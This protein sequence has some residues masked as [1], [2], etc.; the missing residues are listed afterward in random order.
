[1]S[2][3]NMKS[4][5]IAALLAVTFLC[6][7]AGLRARQPAPEEFRR[8]VDL[9]EH[10]LFERAGTLFGS[11]FSATGDVLAK[12]YET[13]CSVRLQEA[14]YEQAVS[15]YSQAYPYS[16]LIPQLH[17]YSGLNLFDKED[18]AL[19]AREFGKVS[20]RDLYSGQIAE[21]SFKKAYSLFEN[22]DIQAAEAGF[23][24]A[25]KMPRSDYTAPSRYSLGYIHYAGKNFREA[26]DW[27]E[28]AARDPRFADISRYY[29]MECRFMQKDYAYVVKNGTGIFESVPKERQMHLARILSESYLATGNSAKA[30]EYYD[31]LAASRRDMDRNDFFYAGS[32]LY[33]VDDFQGAVDNYSRMKDRTDSIGQIASY[34]MGSSYIRT[35]NKVAAL[36]AF[37]EASELSYNPDI[38]EDALFNYAKLSF[39]LNHNPSVFNDYIA[40][41]SDRKKGDRIY[42]YMALSSLYSHDYAGAVE[43]YSHV[44]L[45]DDDQKANYMRANYLRAHQL[46]ESGSWRDAVPCLKAAAWYSDR[47]STF[48]Q[49]A[50]YWLGESLYRSDRFAEAAE[51]FKD[52]YNISALDGKEEGE[53]L[54]FD[55]AYCCFRAEDYA[56]AAKW[57][58]LYLAGKAP[59]RG[60]DAAVRR[61]D[62]DFIRKDYAAAIAGYEAATRRF[63]YSDNLYP[64]YRAGIACGLAGRKE[65][66]VQALSRALDASPSAAWYSETLYELG[67][68]YVAVD[69]SDDAVRCFRKLISEAK[70]KSIAARSL[71]ELGMISRNMS[72]YNQALDYYKQVVAEMPGTEYAEDAFLAIESIYQTQGRVEE[73][74]DYADRV[75]AGKGRTD[76]EKEEMYFAAAEQMFLTENY[77]KA[78]SSLRNYLE[79]YPSGSRVGQACFYTAECCRHLGK[80]EQACDWYKKAIEREDTGSFAEIAMLNFSTLSFEL[81]HFKDAFGGFSSLLQDAKLEN[82]RHTAR[83]GMMRSA[84]RGQDYSAAVSCADKVRSDAGSTPDE[85]REA[86]YLTAKASLSLGERD[87]AFAL[88]GKL[89]AGPSTGE[90]AEAAFMLI[91]DAFDKGLYDEVEKKVYRF[92]DA[93]GDQSYWLAKAFIVLGDAF[94]ER[95]NYPQAKATFESILGGY[96]PAE[97]TTDDV[98][99]NVRMRLGKLQNLMDG[100]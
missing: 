93:A 98:L 43:A 51:T 91:Q 47:R 32:L 65:K 6:P 23:A 44:D 29:M 28:K 22:G 38:Q 67:R 59:A 90:G 46:I 62:C 25:E 68:A 24:E 74:L 77:S 2:D 35:G 39:D 66:K 8:A 79:R 12:G 63:P 56:G 48:N 16:I 33:A 27:F 42:S 4:K 7:G 15:E 19:A 71:I 53:L 92:A 84:W 75:G 73:Y 1:M 61:A 76:S 72:E 83:L 94:A 5:L 20:A 21:Y 41:Y 64:F 55:I 10:G 86:D 97:G 13:L 69:R 30:K 58:D 26:Y 85:L 95:D 31:R 36:E 45:L 3:S 54:P 9:Y 49:L 96:K 70:D 99:D 40:R 82:N 14:G 100:Q 34:Q 80:K 78:L 18:Y 60:E 87:K 50:R 89:A 37:K 52:L 11:V 88:F 17:F 81:E 57:F